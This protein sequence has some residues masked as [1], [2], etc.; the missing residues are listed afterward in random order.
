MLER[1]VTEE[2]VKSDNQISQPMQESVQI[3]RTDTASFNEGNAKVESP[4]ADKEVEQK[5]FKLTRQQLYTLTVLLSH[6]VRFARIKVNRDIDRSVVL[7]KML[8]IRAAKGII[9]PFLVV[10]AKECI[11]EGFEVVDYN[12]N[13]ITKDTP[14][15]DYI[16][17]LIDGQHRWEA[18]KELQAKGEF[19]Q[20]YFISP[21]TDGYNLMTLLK[22]ANTAVN[23]WDGIDWLTMVIQT[24]KGRGLDTAK[25][26]WL[27]EL[28]NTENIS[29]SAASLFASGGEKIYSKAIMKK[30]IDAKDAER[31]EE[32]ADT[33]NLDRNR[34]L[35]KTAM[36][37][38]NVKTVGLKVT[39][40]ILFG[41][42]NQLIKKNI[43]INDA[44]AQVIDF[45]NSL[46]T[47]QV[48][49]LCNAKKTTTKTKDQAITALFKTYWE[50]FV[51]LNNAE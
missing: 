26:E 42:V 34:N 41:F 17:V 20:A 48:E 21:L 43:P 10:E 16:L 4:N 31:L 39:P 18:I 5:A 24:A 35:Y 1:Q 33:G 50:T 45:L 27:K 13:V 51:G 8:S 15:L 32:L 30:A 11:K 14:D 3:N 28:A 9:T 36:I 44:Y 2:L 19:Y 7:K 6:H 46:S 49:A 22:E 23:P 47:E 12:G 37:K 40:K 38:L 29:D 25:L